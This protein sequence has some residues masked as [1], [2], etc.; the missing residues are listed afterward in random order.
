MFIIP[1]GAGYF[2]FLFFFIRIDYSN[3]DGRMKKKESTPVKGVHSFRYFPDPFLSR[4]EQLGTPPYGVIVPRNNNNK[5]G[6]MDG[7]GCLCA[8]L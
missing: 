8:H 5:N 3:G 1:V 7:K 4:Q 6:G 2:C